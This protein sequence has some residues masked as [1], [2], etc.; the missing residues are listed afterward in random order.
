MISSTFR[1]PKAVLFSRITSNRLYFHKHSSFRGAA[2]REKRLA[3]MAGQP[4]VSSPVAL[5]FES[6]RPVAHGGTLKIEY[7]TQQS[8]RRV[9]GLPAARVRR[10]RTSN[11]STPIFIAFVKINIRLH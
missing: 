8:G 10:Y 9:R 6:S 3:E 4:A 11:K 1:I 7:P 5:Q 2:A